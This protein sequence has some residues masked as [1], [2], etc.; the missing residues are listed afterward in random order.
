LK[1]AEKQ[2]NKNQEHVNTG[3]PAATIPSQI[4]GGVEI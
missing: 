1:Q 3:S 4:V 2:Y